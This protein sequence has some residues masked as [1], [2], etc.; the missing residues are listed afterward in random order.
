MGKKARSAPD[1]GRP[2]FEI[3][4]PDGVAALLVELHVGELLQG[5]RLMP[6]TSLQDGV[7]ASAGSAMSQE[8]LKLSVRRKGKTIPPDNGADAPIIEWT[9]DLNGQDLIGP[10]FRVHFPRTRHAFQLSRAWQRIHLPTDAEFEAFGATQVEDWEGLH[11]ATLPD[12]R[13]VA[14]REL[15]TGPVHQAMGAGEDEENPLAGELLASLA[16]LRL[17]I[18]EIDG[19]PP[20]LGEDFATW[21]LSVRECYLLGRWWRDIH[22]GSEEATQ[23]SLGGIRA[24][25]GFGV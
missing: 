7:G 22:L 19:K 20:E 10:L 3:V 23:T 14:M 18:Q 4:L 13:T 25:S 17:A 24:V 16:G 12:G 11:T 5:M 15:A 21:P 2:A 6:K 1:P 9:Q 8:A